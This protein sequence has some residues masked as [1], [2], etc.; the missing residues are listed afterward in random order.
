MNTNIEFNEMQELREQLTLLNNK[1]NQQ[2]IVNDRLIRHSLRNHITS[3]N[4]TGIW[5]CICVLIATPIVA[6]NFHYILHISLA[7][8]LFTCI[9]LIISIFYT[10]WSH[11]GLNDKLLNGDLVTA[12]T[13]ILRT[14]RRYHRWYY[15]SYPWFAVWIC[16]VGYEIYTKVDTPEML[17]GCMVGGI[18][19]GIIGGIWGIRQRN[20]IYRNIDTLLQQIQDLKA[21]E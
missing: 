3:I 19:G 6:Y 10:I 18:V 1:L 5:L 9:F 20:K 16:W 7:L 11:A 8:N 15:F 14:R 2:I 4:R 12:A 21:E 13:T 17:V